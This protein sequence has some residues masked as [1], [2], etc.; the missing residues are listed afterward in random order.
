VATSNY[1]LPPLGGV[2]GLP[3]LPPGGV[4]GLP[5][6]G[7][8][9]GLPPLPPGGVLGLPPL[10]PGGVLGLPPLP[11]AGGLPPL[12]PAG[13]LPKGR[14]LTNPWYTCVPWWY[15]CVPSWFICVHIFEGPCHADVIQLFGPCHADVIQWFGKFCSSAK[16]M[17]FISGR[18]NIFFTSGIHT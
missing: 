1:G 10:P 11:P 15:T 6:L 9:L 16:T 17:A 14:C 5:P 3:P 2:L 4:L 8:V 18:V 12:P 7:G 13:G